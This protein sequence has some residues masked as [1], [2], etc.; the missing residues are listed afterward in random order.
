M[1]KPV[2]NKETGEEKEPTFNDGTMEY[3]DTLSE[4]ITELA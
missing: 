3:M 2:I 1:K 4:I